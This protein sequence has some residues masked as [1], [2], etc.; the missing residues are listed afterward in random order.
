MKKLVLLLLLFTCF[1]CVGQQW[2]RSEY[3]VASGYIDPNA[4]LKENGLNFGLDIE[5]VGFLY[6]RAGVQFFSALPGRYFDINGAIGINLLFGDRV[7]TYAG[8]RGAF[9]IRYGDLYPLVAGEA[10]IDYMIGKRWLIGLRASY[11]L[12][13]DD[14]GPDY[15][16]GNG[17]VRVGFRF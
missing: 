12:R 2:Q 1:W 16:R 7:R 13:T 11:D 9:I 8:G 3:F 17:F 6:T 4:S 15:W 10:G 5:Y 14:A